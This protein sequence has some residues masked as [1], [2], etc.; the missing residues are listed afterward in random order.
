MAINKK[1]IRQIRKIN[2]IYICKKK[3]KVDF[4]KNYRKKI[5]K[6]VFKED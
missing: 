6:L 1:K 2:D 4:S 3:L 5:K